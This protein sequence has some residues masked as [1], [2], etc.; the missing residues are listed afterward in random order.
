MKKMALAGVL[1]VGLSVSGCI[2]NPNTLA[3]TGIGAIG[4]GILGHHVGQGRGKT[5]ATIAGTILGSALGNHVGSVFDGVTHNRNAINRNHMSLHQLRES[6]SSS[7]GSPAP[8]FYHSPYQQQ[9]PNNLRL[10]CR[11]VAN[12]VRCDG[13]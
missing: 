7:S 1:V 8:V 13:S 9:R 6:Q 10:N 11:V 2:S 5:I 3:G 12:Y 4:G